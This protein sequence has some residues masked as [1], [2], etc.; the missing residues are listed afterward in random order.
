MSLTSYLAAPPRG[1]MSSVS[2]FPGLAATYSPASWDAV[3]SA[4]RH[5]TSEFGMGS[6]VLLAPWPP[7]RG[8]ETYHIIRVL[9]LSCLSTEPWYHATVIGGC[10]AFVP[11]GYRIGSSLSGD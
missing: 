3:P 4:Q 5:L 10:G 8:M 1:G 2:P 6:G 11:C 7:D 9:R